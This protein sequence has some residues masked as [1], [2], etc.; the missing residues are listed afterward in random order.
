MGE[1]WPLDER[2]SHPI[3][4]RTQIALNVELVVDLPATYRNPIREFVPT[5]PS[6]LASYS[7]VCRASGEGP[8]AV[9]VCSQLHPYYHILFLSLSSS[10]S[11]SARPVNSSVCRLLLAQIQHFCA[12]AANVVV[13]S[14]VGEKDQNIFRIVCACKRRR[15]VWCARLR[16][17]RDSAPRVHTNTYI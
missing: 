6:A 10:A 17:L 13:V 9:A 15:M 4:R 8:V 5:V 7:P 14:I 16:A 12:A 3:N 1:K 2:T 11:L